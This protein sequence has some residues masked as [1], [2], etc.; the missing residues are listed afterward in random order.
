V[1]HRRPFAPWLSCLVAATLAVAAACRD[2][3]PIEPLQ[4]DGNL[5]TVNNRSTSDWK[6]V[7]I[8]LN[9][10]H[11]VRVPLIAAGARLQVPLDAFVAGFGQRFDV[12]RTQVT[13]VRLTAKLPDGKPLELQMPFREGG[14]AGVFGGKR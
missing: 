11:T 1:R 13:D 9:L 7:E 5:L 14:L 2:Q 8:R 6:D 12:H 3:P 10:N 4:L